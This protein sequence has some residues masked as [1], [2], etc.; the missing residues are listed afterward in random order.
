MSHGN[1]DHIV[2]ANSIDD[3]K[4]KSTHQKKVMASIAHWEPLGI[5]G[6]L[7][8]RPIELV[9]T[10]AITNPY[11]LESIQRSRLTLYAA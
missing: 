8:D 6:D 4:W 9:S 5:G 7:L 2:A 10:A 3:P 1:H 11:F